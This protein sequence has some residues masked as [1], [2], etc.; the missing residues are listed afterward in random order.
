MELGRQGRVL[1]FRR[2]H[3]VV[4]SCVKGELALE[5]APDRLYD[6]GSDN[7]LEE[8]ERTHGR[9]NLDAQEKTGLG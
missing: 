2:Q 6:S 7:S 3:R 9:M 1:L 5:G 4:L 8:E